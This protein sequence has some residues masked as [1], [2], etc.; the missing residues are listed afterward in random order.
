MSKTIRIVLLK[1]IE[2]LGRKFEVKDVA[3]GYAKNFLL[4][5]NLAVLATADLLEKVKLQRRKVLRAQKEEEEKLKA[6]F[7]KV[8]TK[9]FKTTAKASEEGS[10]FGS[11]SRQNV[12]EI[13]RTKGFDIP[14]EV[15]QLDKPIKK[16]G[17]YKISLR[18][19]KELR[20]SIKLKVLAQQK[21]KK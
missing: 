6:V 21:K 15:I 14:E 9:L 20:A 13:L 16:V 7:K 19:G 12:S 8:N 2:N 3:A 5:K 17:D 4:P 11:I 10:L 18:A 1:D